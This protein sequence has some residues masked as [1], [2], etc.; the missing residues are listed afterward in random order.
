MAELFQKCDGLDS[1]T[2]MKTLQEFNRNVAKVIN[3]DPTVLDGLSSHSSGVNK[4]NWAQ[5]IDTG[6]DGHTKICYMRPFNFVAPFK[7]DHY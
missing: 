7:N 3:F 5:K 1:L 6:N 2:A 4:S